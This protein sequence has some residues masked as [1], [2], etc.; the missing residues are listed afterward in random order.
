MK[1]QFSLILAFMNRSIYSCTLYEF[2]DH[3]VNKIKQYNG[4]EER[5]NLLWKSNSTN[6]TEQQLFDEVTYRFEEIVGYIQIRSHKNK[7][8]NKNKIYYNSS[9]YWNSS[10]KEHRHRKY[11]KCYVFMPEKHILQ[12]GVYYIWI[13]L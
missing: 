11:G 13:K 9:E 10:I 6:L 12:R 3:G 1:I 5:K 7:E 4:Y 8:S 2:Q